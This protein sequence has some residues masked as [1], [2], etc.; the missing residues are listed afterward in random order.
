MP[1]MRNQNGVLHARTVA[2]RCLNSGSMML[3]SACS[4]LA[5]SFPDSATS[6]PLVCGAAGGCTM[7]GMHSARCKLLQCKTML[8]GMLHSPQAWMLKQM[9]NYVNQAAHPH[10]PR[11]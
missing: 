5:P 9:K 11:S 1:L 10:S 7:Q 4:E 3:S 8:W 6:M 2:M